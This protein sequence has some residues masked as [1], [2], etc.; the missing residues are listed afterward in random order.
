V[1]LS[2]LRIEEDAVVLRRFPR[3]ERRWPR[4]DVDQFVVL[5]TEGEDGVGAPKL[6]IREPYDYLA[7]RLK[8]GSSVRV[9]S[10]DPEPAT[11]ALRLNNE[12][13]DQPG[14]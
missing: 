1:A 4:R 6:G 14:G 9:P 12:L 13:L 8:D 10:T 11:A 7:L 5:T 2:Y 3:R